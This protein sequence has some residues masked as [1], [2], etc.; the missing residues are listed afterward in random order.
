MTKMTELPTSV[1]GRWQSN[2]PNI[3]QLPRPKTPEGRGIRDA[4]INELRKRQATEPTPTVTDAMLMGII[5]QYMP[6][7]DMTIFQDNDKG[8]EL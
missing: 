7:P 4:Y 8:H 1:T 5:M 2:T 3:Q 6:K